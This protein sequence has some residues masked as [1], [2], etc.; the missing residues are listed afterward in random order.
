MN[1][2]RELL[3]SPADPR[4]EDRDLGLYP[5]TSVTEARTISQMAI[6]FGITPR[7]LRFYENKGLLSPGRSGPVRLYGRQDRDRLALILK[8]KTLGFTLTEIRRMIAADGTEPGALGMSRRQ[9][10]EQIR[11]LEARKREIEA[12]LAEL[13]RTY[14]SSYVRLCAAP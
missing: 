1:D 14:S 6:E 9:C 5:I 11:L 13:R 10:V 3:F 8:A 4:W 7:A 12:A 2:D